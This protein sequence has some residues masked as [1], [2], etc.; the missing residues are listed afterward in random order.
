[1]MDQNGRVD[2]LLVFLLDNEGSQDIAVFG[3]E[4]NR[5][6]LE[7]VLVLGHRR[8]EAWVRQFLIGGLAGGDC[9]QS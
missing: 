3:R 6:P 8:G 2:I 4:L 1:M 7:V 5:F 9:C